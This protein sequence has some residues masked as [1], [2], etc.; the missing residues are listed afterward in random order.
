MHVNRMCSK[1]KSSSGSISRLELI[2]I[3]VISIESVFVVYQ[4][5]SYLVHQQAKGDDAL[6]VNTADSVARVNS[7]SGMNC[8]VNDCD[9]SKG[10][11]THHYDEGYVGYF[12]NNSNTIIG[13][14]P[15][16]YNEYTEMEA[17]GITY[18]GA[19]NS[20]VIKAV[21]K[22]GTVTLSWVPGKVN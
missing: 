3:I 13:T 18:Y 2:L 1:L 21:A 6:M 22:D 12:D 17:S 4:F 11:C 8:V 5:G 14:L 19:V 9:N 20:M 16:G 10:I 7:N 15:S